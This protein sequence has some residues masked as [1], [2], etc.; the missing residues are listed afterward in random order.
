MKSIQNN[1]TAHGITKAFLDKDSTQLGQYYYYPRLIKGLKDR[2][3]K[4]FRLLSL[5][6]VKRLTVDEK[7]DHQFKEVLRK[8]YITCWMGNKLPAA[9]KSLKT[10]TM[11][12][13]PYLHKASEKDERLKRRII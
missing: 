11:N 12:Q 13:K 2:N 6:D 1:T 9:Q 8:T 10:E 4:P 3:Y 7:S 5:L